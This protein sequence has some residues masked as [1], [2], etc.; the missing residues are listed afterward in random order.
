MW[1]RRRRLR[2][3][4]TAPR[5]HLLPSLRACSWALRLRLVL[6]AQ[7]VAPGPLPP[8]LRVPVPFPARAARSLGIPHRLPHLMVYR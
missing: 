8:R 7:A 2:R 3:S 4:Q 6:A 1:L 5:H